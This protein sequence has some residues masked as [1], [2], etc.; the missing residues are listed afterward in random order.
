MEITRELGVA[1]FCVVP[2]I[3]SANRPDYKASP[4]LAA[5]DVRII[6]HT[7]AAWN[8]AALGTLPA[9]IAGA[10]TQV[11]ITLTATELTPD[12]S[13][14]PI[15]IQFIDVTGAEWDDQTILIW[16][17]PVASNITEL[18]SDAQSLA[19]LKDFT[20]AGYD[21]A[22]NKVEGVKLVDTTTTNTD[23]TALNDLSAADVNAECDTAL[24]DY[25][26]PTKTE[27]DSGFAALNDLSAADVNAEV[28]TALVDYDGPTDTEM[29]A[30]FAALNDLSAAD[31]NAEVDT[32]LTDYDGP[33]KTEMDAAFAA[34]NDL[35]SA[36]IQTACDAAITANADINNIDTGV[37]NIEVKLPSKTYLTGSDNSSGDVE[38][39]DATGS[40]PSGAFTNHPDVDL[41]DD[42]ITSAKYDEI[43]AFPVESV[44]SGNSQIART[45]AD[46]D[47]LE[48]LSD[49]MDSLQTGIDGIQNNTK[50]VA[51]V[52]SHMLIPDAGDTMYKLSVHFYDSDGNME[53]P[54]S[55]E[56]DILYEDVSGADKDAFYDNAGG[57]VGATAGVIDINM[58][59]MVKIGVGH[60]ETYYKLPN[61]E[62]IDQWTASFKLE[63]SSTELN[64]A[65]STNVVE[66]NPG[67]TT[68][69]DNVSNATVIAEALKEIN[70]SGASPVAGS[71]YQDV[72]DNIDANGTAIGALN[73]VSTAEVNASCDTALADYDGPTKTEMDSG[74]AALNDI[75]TAEVNIEVDNALADYDGPTKTELDSGFAA[76]ND[77]SA[78][79]VNA[80]VDTALAEYDGPTSTE[81]TNAFAALNDIST[82]EVNTEVDTALTDY[83]GPT[84]IEM[85]NAF[86]ALNDISAAEVNT[87]VDTALADYDAP[88]KTEMDSGF[89]ALNDI[90]S[91]GV[92]A[93]CDA[94][95]TAN[96]DIDNID[97]GVNNIEAKLPTNY[98]MGS[99]VQTDKDDEIDAIKVQTDKLNFN[100]DVTPLVL[101]DIRNVN[102]VTVTSVDDFKAGASDVAGA[103]VNVTE[104]EGAD[105]T[106]QLVAAVDASI[107]SYGL[108]HLVAVAVTGIDVADDSIIANMVSKSV[109]PDYDSFDNTNDSLEAIRDNQSAGSGLTAQQTRDAMKLAPTGGAPAAGSVDDHLDDIGTPVALDGGSAD[110]SGMLTK[111]A[112]DNGGADFD[113]ETDSLEKLGAAAGGTDWSTNEKNEIKAVLGITNTG[114]PDST[115]ADG[116]LKEIQDN[117]DTV[118]S[119]ISALNDLSAAE[120]N[121]EVDNALVDINLDHLLA[122]ADADDVVDNSVIAKLADNTFGAADWSNYSNSIQSLKSILERGDEAWRT[123]SGASGSES[124]VTTDWTRTIGDNDGGVGSDTATVNAAYFST[125]EIGTGSYLEVDAVFSITDGELGI[126][127]DVWGFYDGGGS[128]FIEVQARNFT[129]STWEPVGV[130]ALGD[131]V[132]KHSFNLSP[133]HTDAAGDEVWLKFLHKGGSGITSHVLSID[134]AQVNTAIPVSNE[135]NVIQWGGNAV[136]GDGDWAELQ[137]AVDA[138]QTDLDNGTDGLGAIKGAIDGLNDLSAAEVNAEVD[139]ALSDYDGPTNTEMLAGFAALNDISALEVNAEV[140]TALADYDSPTNTEMLAAFAALNNISTAEVNTEVDTALTDYDGP[141]KTEMDNSFAAL[142]DLSAAQVNAEVDT[143]LTDYDGPTKTEMDSGFAGLNDLSAADVNAEAEAALIDY[144]SSGGVAKENSVLAL[145][146]QTRFVG[147]PP[148]HM[149]IPDAGDTIYRI[150]SHFYDNDGN[151]EDP[152]N[153]EIAI[154]YK[155]VSGTSKIAFFDNAAG[156]SPA[157]ASTTFSGKYKMVKLGVG[158]YETYYKL[159]NTEAVAQWIAEF[160]LEEGSVQ[161]DYSRSTNVVEENPGNTTL[162]DNATNKTIVAE[163][164]KEIDVNATSAVSGSIHKDI[165]DNVDANETAIG[166][167]NDLSAA[168]VNTEV[169]TALV[170]YDGPTKTEMDSGFAALNNLSAAEVNAEVDTALSDY[171]G[172]TKTEMD[173]A[174]AALNDLSAAEVNIECDQALTD[175]DGPTYTEMTGAFAAL[176]D[177]STAEVNAEVDTALADYDG[178]NKTEMDAAFAALNDISA[179]EVNAEVDTALMDYDGP[180][181]TEMD[182]GFAALNDLSAAE[183][184]AEVDTALADI[185][186]DELMVTTLGSQPV[187]GSVLGD[188]TEDDAGT[189]RFTTNALEQAPSGTGGDASA[190]NQTAILDHLTDVKG[191]GFVKD[192]DSMVDLTHQAGTK[193]SDNIYDNIAALNDISAADVNAEIDTALADI[194]LD[195]LMVTTLGSQPAA[196]SML[197]DLTEDDAGIQRFTTNALEQAPSGTGGDASAANQAA[198]I[199][200]LTDV[201]GTGFVKDTDSMVDLSHQAGTKGTD[202]VYDNIAALN[203]ISAAEVN[204][205]VDTALTDY[206]GPT[207]TEMDAG[208]AALNDISTAEVNAEVDTALSDIGL[209]HLVSAAVTGTDVADDSIIAQMVSKSA[210][211]DFD[212]FDNTTDALEAIADGAGGGTADWT[213]AEKEQIRDALGVDGDKTDAVSGQLQVI[214]NVV[215]GIGIELDSATYG[216]AAIKVAVDDIDVA[217]ILSETLD[218][219]ATVGIGLKKMLAYCAG[220]LN[221]I[222]KVYTYRNFDNTADEMVHTVGGGDPATNR[223]RS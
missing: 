94:A 221:R 39:D 173:N 141:T 12:D 145:Q 97:T 11:L 5:A 95:I 105:A 136:T 111:L 23:V 163:A 184:N 197:G 50:F 202:N 190:A 178:P 88:T 114:T 19:D 17:R 73:D 147:V 69:A 162:A 135:A 33:T 223:T 208:F 154:V 54:D 217:D 85:T 210:T 112:D 2:L 48:T 59:K 81:M 29:L 43:T 187:A 211:A 131:T 132:Q 151:M 58:W 38:L 172:P 125:G 153:D 199:A 215:D 87:E 129:D 104:I 65:R 196:G 25:D 177:I 35:D 9:V 127:V 213:A 120:V 92:Q 106:T 86:A 123:G 219:T 36:G 93:A 51:T 115:P 171:D 168:E 155:N 176:N 61:T 159:P 99:A 90:D 57:S 137:T 130:M 170:D 118:E 126:S 66:E 3:D 20:D 27:L 15:I 78:A 220:N 142:N 107:E 42:A 72:M 169:D 195:E 4:T 100:A 116:V 214:D 49:Q 180:T 44:D 108:D 148:A 110:I 1:S 149:L 140:D 222:A 193:G 204:T 207:N 91:S 68:L 205:E 160:S 76:L 7:G 56:I 198:I 83:D 157:T 166:A 34:L 146:N 70:V 14:Y 174:F 13:K 192:T 101:V 212:S 46:T 62:T 121:T 143:A 191:T 139:T 84:A 102:D 53:D 40:L 26:G 183:V 22:T 21:P 119:A 82:A 18:D 200:H 6:R 158:T 89:A 165:M 52:P 152:D 74:F 55:D 28:D 133:G 186:L 79:Q 185:R 10:T 75:S 128:H 98:I 96:T 206:D 32:A 31:V 103:D 124:Y 194:R 80:E 182:A 201:K 77:L 175:Y 218:G 161:L 203:D 134:K 189:Q 138:I 37:N 156:S 30:A 45:G 67:A 144:D 164:L 216:L 117:V 71:I 209:D 188:L 47:T 179:A 122:V 109:T 167:L 16:T 63:E 24:S 150:V 113:A 181:K 64:Y 8:V 41:A 60:Y